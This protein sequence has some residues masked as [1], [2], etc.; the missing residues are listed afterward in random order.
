MYSYPLRCKQ[1]EQTKMFKVRYL[2]H[3]KRI[4]NVPTS[5]QLS[6][7]YGMDFFFLRVTF[8]SMCIIHCFHEFNCRA[9]LRPPV[10]IFSFQSVAKETIDVLDSRQQTGRVGLQFNSVHITHYESRNTKIEL[11]LND[12]ENKYWHEII[13]CRNTSFGRCSG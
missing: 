11:Y 8:R 6:L 1:H 3:H 12:D 10:L 2:N 13:S 7:S 4:Y 9:E 5:E